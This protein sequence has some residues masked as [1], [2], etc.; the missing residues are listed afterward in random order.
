MMKGRNS[1]SFCLIGLLLLGSILR[2]QAQNTITISGFVREKSTK[3]VLIGANIATLDLAKATATNTYGFY[4]LSIPR[5]DDSVGIQFSFIGYKLQKVVIAANSN[6]RLDV[7]LAE[8]S[9][10]LQ[11]VE[12]TATP[13]YLTEKNGLSSISLPAKTIKELPALLGEKDP[14]KVLQLMPGVSNPREGFSG[15]YVRK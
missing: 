13:Q 12:V 10:T 8:E 7:D 14:L 5:A 9:A 3:E 4:S 1:L 11:T 2:G 6:V 15:I